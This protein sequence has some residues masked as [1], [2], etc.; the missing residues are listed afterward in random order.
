MKKQQMK[1]KKGLHREGRAVRKAPFQL[2]PHRMLLLRQ[3]SLAQAR[4]DSSRRHAPK[5][6][7][8]KPTQSAGEDLAPLRRRS[9]PAESQPSGARIRAC[10]PQVARAPS[11]D[12][13]SPA[14]PRRGGARTVAPWP[15]KAGSM[16]CSGATPGSQAQRQRVGWSWREC[17]QAQL[18]REQAGHRE[19]RPRMKQQ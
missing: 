6:A 3:H 15:C 9:P 18:A 19:R 13:H 4:R 14:A 5:M 7:V 12:P 16:Q 17:G 1:M 2:P 10:P 11:Q 8:T